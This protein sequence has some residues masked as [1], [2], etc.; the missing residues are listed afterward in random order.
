MRFGLLA[1][2]VAVFYMLL[3]RDYPITADWQAWYVEAS[4]FAMLVAG[5]L[6]L[7]GFFTSL[8]GRRLLHKGVLWD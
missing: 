1:V 7:Y 2:M 5:G 6:A 8:A 4:L 3:L